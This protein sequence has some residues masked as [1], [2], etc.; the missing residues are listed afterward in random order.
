MNSSPS[1]LLLKSSSTSYHKPIHYGVESFLNN[2]PEDKNSKNM[3]DLDNLPT[4]DIPSTVHNL[5]ER[6]LSISNNSPQYFNNS[7][8]SYK[9]H[10]S[11]GDMYHESM[12]SPRVLTSHSNRDFDFERYDFQPSTQIISLETKPQSQELEQP[13]PFSN[14]RLVNTS[15]AS[16]GSKD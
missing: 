8:A 3:K 13:A 11:P 1:V 7:S 14:L 10:N 16:S 9:S 2:P 12:A 6:N 5:S 15:V 4:P